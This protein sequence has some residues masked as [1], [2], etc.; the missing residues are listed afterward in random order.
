V[1]LAGDDAIDGGG[2][3]AVVD[4]VA[5][6]VGAAGGGEVG[7]DV[8]VDLEGLGPLRLLGQRPVNAQ[9]AEAPELDP[10]AQES[11]LRSRT[12]RG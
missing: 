5:E 9:Q 2:D 7:T 12:S 6:G 11:A 1:A 4:G 3:Q 10:I 8:Q